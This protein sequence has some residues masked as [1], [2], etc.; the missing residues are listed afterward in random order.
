MFMKCI[1]PTGA[2]YFIP[3]ESISLKTRSL[4][5]VESELP[6]AAIFTLPL[7]RHLFP[8]LGAAVKS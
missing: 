7:G 8:E 1:Y 5:V 4:E 6:E 2:I 3:E